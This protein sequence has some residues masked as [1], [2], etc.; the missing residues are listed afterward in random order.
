MQLR[1]RDVEQWMS[2]RRLPDHLRRYEILKCSNSFDT[3]HLHCQKS[4]CKLIQV[5]TYKFPTPPTTSFIYYVH[6]Q[7]TATV[8]HCYCITIN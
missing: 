8:R 3:S 4:V 1:G 2:H 7:F 6:E 5:I